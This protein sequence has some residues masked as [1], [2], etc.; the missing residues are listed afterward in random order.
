MAVNEEI[1][2][3]PEAVKIEPFVVELAKKARK[4]NKIKQD[5]YKYYNVKR[6]LRNADGPAEL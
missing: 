5:L 4:N 3:V 1:K 2:I 6:G